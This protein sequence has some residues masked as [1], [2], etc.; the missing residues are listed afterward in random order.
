MARKFPAQPCA[1]CA[2]LT[3]PEHLEKHHLVPRSEGGTE[4]IVV[5]RNCGDQIHLLFSN[6]ELRDHY[7]TLEKLQGEPRIQKWVQWIRQRN[8]FTFSMKT[9]KRR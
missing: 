1:L 9:K 5:C 7:P 3:P 2:R 4:T 6:D 8:S